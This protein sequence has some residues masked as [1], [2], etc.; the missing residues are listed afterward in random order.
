MADPTAS[1]SIL[2]ATSAYSTDFSTDS[3]FFPSEAAPP[4]DSLPI[5]PTTPTEDDYDDPDGAMFS[6]P[7]AQS[8]PKSTATFRMRA[9]SK[10]ELDR[11]SK[12]YNRER[13]DERNERDDEEDGRSTRSG[14]SRRSRRPSSSRR[15]SRR[16]SDATTAGEET[17]AES[18]RSTTASRKSSRARPSPSRRRSRSSRPSSPHDSES[19]NERSFFQGI[20][21]AIR[22]RPSPGRKDSSPPSFRGSSRRRR[23]SNAQS[24][25]DEDAI[26]TRSESEVG[27]DQDPYGP[28]GSS[29]TASTSTTQSSSS[30]DD[31]PRRRRGGAGAIFGIPGASD[32]FFGESRV[33]FDNIS[34]GD[35]D[36]FDGLDDG[37][38]SLNAQQLL[39]IPDEDLPLRLVGLR[40]SGIKSALW[41]LGCIL[42]L[43]TLWLLGRWVPSV[44]LRAVG[45]PGEFDKASYLVIEVSSFYSSRTSSI[46]LMRF[47]RHRIIPLKSSLSKL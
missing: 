31:A 46:M 39:Y 6:G 37:K 12:E 19:D 30:Q 28:Y 18:T 33:D 14:K 3:Q 24:D 35:D 1:S 34:E 43:G 32:A 11:L 44:W 41:T 27:D 26:S 10:G 16:N 5:R 8:V 45:R 7:A 36:S 21:D 4:I 13:A 22:G 23:S 38:K 47:H 17:D 15:S 2:K 25:Y 9:R 40:V 42:S 29:D 20:S